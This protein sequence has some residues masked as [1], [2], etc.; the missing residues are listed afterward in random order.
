MDNARATHRGRASAVSPVSQLN[1][2]KASLIYPTSRMYLLDVLEAEWRL[3]ARSKT[4]PRS[5]L[6]AATVCMPLGLLAIPYI[7]S[8]DHCTAL[9]Y[10]CHMC[11]PGNRRRCK[12]VVA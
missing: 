1:L 7:A 5:N 9:A 11:P 2:A 8:S 10:I 4:T 6:M 3:G 12:V